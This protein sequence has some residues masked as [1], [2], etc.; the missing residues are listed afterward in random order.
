MTTTK[1]HTATEKQV[2]Y[3]LFLL[4]K[5]GYGADWMSR[6][7]SRWATM[8]ERQGR[9]DAWLSSLPGYRVSQII[10][11]LKGDDA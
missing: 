1:T 11:D 3:A 5:H 9:V 2:R 6:R 8:R 10:D 4:D 7:H